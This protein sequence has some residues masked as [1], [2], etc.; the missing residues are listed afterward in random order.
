MIK[1]A[2]GIRHTRD[3]LRDFWIKTV[4]VDCTVVFFCGRY[5]QNRIQHI[6][7]RLMYGAVKIKGLDLLVSDKKNFKVL[8][9]GVYVEKFDLSVEKVK[10]NRRLL[11][12][13]ILLGPYTQ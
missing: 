3:C 9:I 8:P 11:F 10:V 5:E 12:F 7:Y 6:I 2:G 13:Q 4:W 1:R